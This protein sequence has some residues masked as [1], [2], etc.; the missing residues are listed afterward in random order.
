MCTQWNC[1]SVKHLRFFFNCLVGIFIFIFFKI[2]LQTL[3]AQPNWTAHSSYPWIF[4][5]GDCIFLDHL[6][7][8]HITLPH[9]STSPKYNHTSRAVQILSPSILHEVIISSIGIIAPSPEQYYFMWISSKA[10]F[11]FTSHAVILGEYA[12][13]RVQNSHQF[14]LCISPKHFTGWRAWHTHKYILNESVM[15]WKEKWWIS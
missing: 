5:S 6:E 2:P 15:E 10:S 7:P 8:Q 4:G 3:L 11:H 13:A 12:A 14:Y 1:S 9:I